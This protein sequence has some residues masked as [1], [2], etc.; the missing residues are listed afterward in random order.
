[1]AKNDKQERSTGAA[2]SRADHVRSAVESA[3]Q[4]AGSQIGRDRALDLADELASAATR[5]REALEELRPPTT[6]DLKRIG[7][8]LSAIERRLG[9]LEGTTSMAAPPKSVARPA[10]GAKRR[11]G[12]AKAAAKPKAAGGGAK[13]A[14]RPKPA[15]RPKAA[16][17]SKAAAKPKP[18]ARPKPASRRPAARPRPTR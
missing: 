16:A 6:D 4:A 3:F 2:G 15:A 10:R 5:V 13:A 7:A 11:T 1:M 12:A 8:R 14:A 17:R 18:A 9:V